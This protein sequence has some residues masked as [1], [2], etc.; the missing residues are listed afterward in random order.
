MQS[1]VVILPD[2]VDFV[3]EELLVN[4]LKEHNTT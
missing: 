4:F 3:N 2:G 1:G